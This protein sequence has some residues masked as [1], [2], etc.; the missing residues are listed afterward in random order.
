MVR[1]HGE[2]FNKR[3]AD[4]ELMALYASGGGKSHGQR[5]TNFILILCL[6]NVMIYSYVIHV[7]GIPCLLALSTPGM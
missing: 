2:G 7:V 5:V 4:I 3:E 6:C 1:R